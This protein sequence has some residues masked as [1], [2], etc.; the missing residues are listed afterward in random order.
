MLELQPAS[1][2]LVMHYNVIYFPSYIST[3]D[4][5]NLFMFLN[6]GF[7]QTNLILTGL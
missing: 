3:S 4:Q 6:Q 2:I 5:E 1:S 7:R